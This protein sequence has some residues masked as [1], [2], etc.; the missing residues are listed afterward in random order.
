M[1][2]RFGGWTGVTSKATGFFRVEKIDGRWWFI[3]P[4]GNAFIEPLGD[5]H[6]GL[7]GKIKL[8]CGG[9]L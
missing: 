4:D 7:G 6:S 5:S 1:L 8:V 9:L 3:D 2:D